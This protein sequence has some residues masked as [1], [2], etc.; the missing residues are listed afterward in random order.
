[1]PFEIVKENLASMAVDAIV[2]AD[3]QHTF[4][5]FN[6][7]PLLLQEG[8]KEL[9]KSRQEVG[10]VAAGEAKIASAS[11]LAAKYIIHTAAPVWH[12]G[13]YNELD[14]LRSCYEKVFQLAAEHQCKS[15]ALPIIGGSNLGFPKKLT[16]RTTFECINSFLCLHDMNLSLV[17]PNKTGIILPGNR[18]SEV[19]TYLSKNYVDGN[20]DS[21]RIPSD[22]SAP[23]FSQIIH[24][25]MAKKELNESD[26]CHKANIPASLFSDILDKDN[27]DDMKHEPDKRAVLSLGVALGLAPEEM[28]DFIGHAGYSLT[29]NSKFD[30][31]I[32]YCIEKNI[33]DIWEINQILFRFEQEMLGGN[34]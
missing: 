19:N 22:Q 12:G 8:G 18:F 25:W 10:S 33:Y 3:T 32:K 2:Y 11:N 13:M 29:N 21:L 7:N 5:L 4:S 9:S 30:L 28:T 26:I 27:K 17:L 34:I 15:I 14:Q 23:A 16:Q 24:Q 6:F 20:D 31:I 1:M